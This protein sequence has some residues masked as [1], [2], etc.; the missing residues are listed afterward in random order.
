MQSIDD[1]EVTGL[2]VLVRSDLNVP[3]DKSGSGVIT[4]DGRIRASLPVIR[5]LAEQLGQPV[6][7]RAQSGA[8][9]RPLGEV[10]ALG[11]AEVRQHHD[12]GAPLGELADHRQ[13]GPDA[14][15]VGDH[16]AAG[17][18]ERD[19]EVGPDQ[20]P[21]AGEVGSEVVDCLHRD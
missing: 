14:P 10:G 9:R 2:R 15:V 21:A 16:A 18:V 12:P 13:R 3:L 5:K 17:L 8:A 4:D 7:D 11:P 1:I 20:D 19:V 6:G